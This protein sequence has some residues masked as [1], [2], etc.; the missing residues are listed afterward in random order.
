MASALNRRTVRSSKRDKKTYHLK[1]IESLF[2]DKNPNIRII[3]D[4][5]DSG[6]N[7]KVI[8]YEHSKSKEN[9]I[10]KESFPKKHLV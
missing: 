7:S 6:S 1:N 8:L 3:S 10:I 2:N 4:I 9:F 5:E